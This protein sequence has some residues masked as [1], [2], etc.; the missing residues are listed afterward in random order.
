MKLI[1]SLVL[2]GAIVSAP[3]HARTGIETFAGTGVKGFSGDGGPATAAQLNNPFGVARGTDG[4]LY[5]CDCDNHRI[6]KVTPDGVIHTV[7]GNG[8]RGYSGD[9]GPAIAA[10]LNEPYEIRVDAAG[11]IFF[12][13]R[14]N[15]CVRRVDAKTGVIS[16]V[17]GTGKAGFSEIG[18]A[19]V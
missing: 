3:C 13:E 8:S 15:H 4:A 1:A 19:H 18:R 11:N 17:A 16:T 14:M 7:A 9:G 5:I 10:P 2:F 12:V 6:R